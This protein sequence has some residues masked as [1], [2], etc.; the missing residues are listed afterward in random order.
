MRTAHKAF[1]I[2][3]LAVVIAVLGILATITTVGY[4]KLQRDARDT[5]RKSDISI[6]QS[7]LETHY[8]KTGSYPQMSFFYS[9][10]S[11]YGGKK[12]TEVVNVPV[13]A[14]TDPGQASPSAPLYSYPSQATWSANPSAAPTW[15]TS[16]THP[17]VYLPYTAASSPCQMDVGGCA[18]YSLYYTSEI[19]GRQ[20]IRSRYGW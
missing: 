12:F 4:T 15:A 1:S 17:Y 2:V 11:A 8:E 6:M 16:N 9:G 3:E 18:R 13:A 19:E 20:E 14:M 5:E 10:L 7:A